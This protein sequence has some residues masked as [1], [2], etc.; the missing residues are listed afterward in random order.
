MK[1]VIFVIRI[2]NWGYKKTQ[3]NVNYYVL[4]WKANQIHLH[5]K[6]IIVIITRNS[7]SSEV[8]WHITQR[9]LIAFFKLG[10]AI[11]T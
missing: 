7:L 3:K 6:V 1:L 8:N 5:S 9:D 2:K 11:E 10:K 4:I